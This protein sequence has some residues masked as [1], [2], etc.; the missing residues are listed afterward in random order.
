MAAYALERFDQL[1][2]AWEEGGRLLDGAGHLSEDQRFMLTHAIRSY[3]GST[4]LLDAGGEP[5]GWSTR[6][7]T[8]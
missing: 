5:F 8:A 3:Y 7:S 1:K 2:R 6:G 4:Q